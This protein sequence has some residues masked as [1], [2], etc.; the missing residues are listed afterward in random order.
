MK[1]ERQLV[2]RGCV[3]VFFFFFFS[4]QGMCSRKRTLVL[5]LAV[6]MVRRLD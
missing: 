3:T 1:A 4:V 2:V 6:S 5:L